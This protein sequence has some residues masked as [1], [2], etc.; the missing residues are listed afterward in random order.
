MFSQLPYLTMAKVDGNGMVIGYK[1]YG[2]L[3]FIMDGPLATV[4]IHV[5]NTFFMNERKIGVFCY[6]SNNLGWLRSEI[7]VFLKTHNGLLAT[8][9][10]SS[11]IKTIL[12]FFQLQYFEQSVLPL[13]YYIRV[14]YQVL[15]RILQREQS[16]SNQLDLIIIIIKRYKL[17]KT[18]KYI[19]Y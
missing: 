5:I 12:S 2:S 6:K 7:Y 18:E 1:L 9:K 14:S 11:S 8:V 3:L 19:G 17:E 15:L 16:Y 10:V 13:Y 4:I